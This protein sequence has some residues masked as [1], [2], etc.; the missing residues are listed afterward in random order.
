[1]WNE[2][3]DRNFKESEMVVLG[4]KLLVLMS[5]K[6]RYEM[7]LFCIWKCNICLCMS[8]LTTLS[9][10]EMIQYKVIGWQVR[11]ES[12]PLFGVLSTVLSPYINLTAL[13]GRLCG[14]IQIHDSFTE[15]MYLYVGF[16]VWFKFLS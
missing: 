10:A 11:Y 3:W 5:K 2:N 1:M 15:I 8:Y 14:T 6:H 16:K 12:L 4:R 13:E 9:S 7:R